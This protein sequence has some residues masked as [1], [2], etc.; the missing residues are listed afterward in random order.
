MERQ[1]TAQTT[2]APPQ[3]SSTPAVQPVPPQ[4]TSLPAFL[5]MQQ[6]LGNQAV[7]R[8]YRAGV[9][10]AKLKIGAPGDKYEQ[11]AD[12]VADQVMRMPEPVTARPGEDDE[13]KFHRKPLVEQISPLVQRQVA[14]EK[15]EKLQR[16]SWFAAPLPLLQRAVPV[17]VRE[18]DEEKKIRTKP[19][20][21]QRLCLECEKEKEKPA[22]A[23]H[24]DGLTATLQRQEE[25][26]DEAQTF[27]LQRQ[28]EEDESAQAKFASTAGPQL[29]RQEEK[30]DES[31][32]TK[33]LLQRQEKKEEEKPAQAKFAAGL[34]SALQR[35][36]EKEDESAQAMNVQRRQIHIS[37]PALRAKPGGN[38]EMHASSAVEARVSHSRGS[39]SALPHDTRAFMEPRFG[40]D[41]S[42][43][44]VH[45]GT[46]AA[47]M[48]QDLN[49][50]AFT[51]GRDIYFGN[52]KY[53]PQ[54]GGGQQLLAHEL[55]HVVQQQSLN[56]SSLQKNPNS[57][58]DVEVI[59]QAI[60]N[61]DIKTIKNFDIS[62]LKQATQLQRVQL[63]EIL[64][65]QDWVGPFDESAIIKIFLFTE[66]SKALLYLFAEH[67][68]MDK[69]VSKVDNPLLEVLFIRRPKEAIQK[70]FRKAA[71]DR[72][73]KYLAKNR[74]YMLTLREQYYI[75]ERCSLD[76]EPIKDRIG[77][78]KDMAES[79]I[80]IDKGIAEINR[81][82][83]NIA[84]RQRLTDPRT[85]LVPPTRLATTDI[86]VPIDIRRL[87]PKERRYFFDLEAKREILFKGKRKL[88]T[89]Y[90]ILIPFIEDRDLEKFAKMESAYEASNIIV[91]KID[92]VI[93][94]ISKTEK[95]ITGDDDADL[96]I[97]DVPKSLELVKEENAN[98]SLPFEKWAVDEMIKSHH[99]KKMW[100]N[101]GIGAAAGT[102]F[103]I[104]ELVTAGWATVVWAGIGVAIGA[105]GATMNMEE[106]LDLVTASKTD[107]RKDR[108][109]VA[110]EAADSAVT[111][112]AIDFI[113]VA[114]DIIQAGKAL[115][116]IS[117][118]K[119][120]STEELIQVGE[121]IAEKSLKEATKGGSRELTKA[122]EEILEEISKRLD[123][124]KAIFGNS[125]NI[126]EETYKAL[127][128]LDD[129]ILKIIAKKGDDFAEDLGKVLNQL[130]K[131]G[132][133]GEAKAI[134][135]TLASLKPSQLKQ[136]TSIGDK[137]PE[138]TEAL[139]T[140]RLKIGFKNAN[141]VID[142]FGIKIIAKRRIFREPE[143]L[144]SIF[145]FMEKGISKEKIIKITEYTEGYTV[146]LFGKGNVKPS[147]SFLDS[148]TKI[149]DR[150]G[151]LKVIE[152][153]GANMNY[154]KGARWV[155]EFFSMQNKQ[156]QR[157]ISF[158]ATHTDAFGIKRVYDIVADGVYHQMKNWTRF[159]DKSAGKQLY[160]DLLLN[161]DL[162]SLR[163]VFRSKFM[164]NDSLRKAMVKAVEDYMKD[165]GITGES[166]KIMLKMLD[167]F[168]K[169]F[170]DIVI[171]G[172]IKQ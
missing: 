58:E 155:I 106:A 160:K 80:N 23:K 112:A 10:Q 38:G 133:A 94:N 2:S 16:Q 66:D 144:E 48:S 1:Q 33:S 108:K 5:E 147:V 49:A 60:K 115:K 40:V 124:V 146:Q 114:L 51:V 83:F 68:N 3:R 82:I 123:D 4:S 6:T 109:L 91:E 151:G 24:V 138:V 137:I 161:P 32:Q 103:I 163:W 8:L 154:H 64:L 81:L 158:E 25:K 59:K 34:S 116:G 153:L 118:L 140:L 55:T 14:D 117:S 69:L 17:A 170:D 85:Y 21:M 36:E 53:N 44:R 135:N 141:H 159:W 37:P 27:S 166:A 41:F 19:I 13:K 11:E 134:S 9:L 90:P 157:I 54:T 75:P 89:K 42:Q 148:A 56:K 18:D 45:T 136:L 63:I 84:M 39:G 22:Q 79:Y 152:D 70:E 120:A 165:Q 102:A 143:A 164:D 86:T 171:N 119:K 99:R 104:S 145:K 46:D 29:Q 169:N 74:E 35:Q 61:K 110:K 131:Q 142:E 73:K 113:L 139:H 50:Q 92:D 65:D 100:R 130:I 57:G 12:R 47:Q 156:I 132:N 43:V 122:G 31:A 125:K 168:E 93:E 96:N 28:K 62:I 26:E 67:E 150:P 77:K 20:T 97:L 127:S 72:A 121:D 95:M 71:V 98:F 111:W 149:L 128:V 7:Q 129:S 167:D 76:D 30:E 88:E 87:S 172:I 101:L 78:L 162:K 107:I 15:D 52:G 126:S 105:I